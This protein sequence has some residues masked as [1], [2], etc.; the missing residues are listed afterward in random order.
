ME[1]SS[2]A[3]VSNHRHCLDSMV[4]QVWVLIPRG[5]VTSFQRGHK[6]GWTAISVS[7]G[8]PRSPC[9]LCAQLQGSCCSLKAASDHMFL[10]IVREPQSPPTFQGHLWR[11]CTGE[12]LSTRL[13]QHP[14]E[15][16]LGRVAGKLAGDSWHCHF[17]CTPS[18]PLSDQED[19]HGVRS[20][21][22]PPRCS[23]RTR[24]FLV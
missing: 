19:I 23:A 17:G 11:R 2:S 20:P 13:M 24:L 5:V 14:Q 4:F 18:P 21:C 8:V 7:S 10:I 22:Q 16:S 6:W 15:R 9:A 3:A 1:F 12:A